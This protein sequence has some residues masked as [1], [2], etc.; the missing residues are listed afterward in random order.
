MS[1]FKAVIAI[2][3]RPQTFNP[4][5]KAVKDILHQ[6][7]FTSVQSVLMGTEWEIVYEAEDGQEAYKKADQIA[8]KQCNPITK[9]YRIVSVEEI[10]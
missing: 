4:E 3:T 6:L 1:Q 2:V 8:E 7:G 9:V 10:S 5:E